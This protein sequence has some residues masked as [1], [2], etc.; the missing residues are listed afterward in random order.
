MK[1]IIGEDGVINIDGKIGSKAEILKVDD[2]NFYDAIEDG[3]KDTVRILIENNFETYSSCQ[4]HN[5][6]SYSL[7]NVVVVLDESEI[8][9]WRAMIAELN[10]L[11]AFKDPI[12]YIIVEYKNNKKGFMIIFGSIYQIEETEYKQKCFEECIPKI[13]GRYYFKRSKY[14][15]DYTAKCG[16]INVFNE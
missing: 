10:I 15:T 2:P 14:I 7:R 13:R 16:H 12:T 3:I 1:N 9:F 4:G 5:A 8:D 11:K 6:P